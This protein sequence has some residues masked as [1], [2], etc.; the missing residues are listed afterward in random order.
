[1]EFPQL[2]VTQVVY[3]LDGYGL[4]IFQIDPHMDA[5]SLGRYRRVLPLFEYIQQVVIMSRDRVSRVLVFFVLFLF[6]RPFGTNV[7]SFQLNFVFDFIHLRVP[8]V[9]PLW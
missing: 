9:S 4:S 1:V 8:V 3:L 5:R 7:D 2:F 6:Y